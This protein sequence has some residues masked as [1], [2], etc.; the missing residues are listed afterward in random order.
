MIEIMAQDFTLEQMQF[1]KIKGEIPD[2]IK[3]KEG[4]NIEEVWNCYVEVYFEQHKKIEIVKLG[5]NKQEIEIA[6]NRGS[7][8][9]IYE[10]KLIDQKWTSESINTIRES[11]KEILTLVRTIV[12][13]N[14]RKRLFE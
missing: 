11:S 9:K 14:L 1:S 7:S 2:Y 6:T 3:S 10:Q 12:F 5:Q 4:K 13:F 8:W